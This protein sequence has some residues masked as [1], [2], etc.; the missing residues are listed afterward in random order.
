M[1]LVAKIP[2][3]GVKRNL[4][5]FFDENNINLAV[6]KRLRALFA[7]SSLFQ[8]ERFQVNLRCQSLSLLPILVRTVPYLLTFLKPFLMLFI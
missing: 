8:W 6:Q 2:E 5:K 1:K 7:H 4:A 3:K